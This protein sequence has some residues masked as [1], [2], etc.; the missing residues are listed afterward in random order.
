MFWVG[1]S[2]IVIPFITL[3]SYVLQLRYKETFEKARGKYHT[4][5]DAL[6]VIYHR[7]VTDDISN[8]SGKPD[9]YTFPQCAS[10]L[11]LNSSFITIIFLLFVG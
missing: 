9:M 10:T 3:L 2:A 7:K 11:N 6:D 1:G 4:V 5:K 8:V